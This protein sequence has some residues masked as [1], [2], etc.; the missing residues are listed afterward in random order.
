MKLKFANFMANTA[1]GLLAA[2]FKKLASEARPKIW[3]R[4][5]REYLGEL[6]LDFSDVGRMDADDIGR[7]VN[8]WEN[9]RWRRESIESKT[10]LELYRSKRNMG[11]EGIYS[12]EYGSV[13]LFQCRI[14]TLKLRWRQ[15]FKGGAVDCLLCG[16]EEETVR[17]F[18]MECCELQ[19]IRRRYYVYG[20]DALEE[21]LLFMEKSEEKVDRCKKMLKEMWRR[22]IEQL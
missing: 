14:N 9:N 11:D 16:G 12:N 10:T 19:E 7:E 21:V 5:L 6:E 13:L 1:N 2:I 22:R 20:T 15:G 17:H 8:N 4:Q 18:V 3:V